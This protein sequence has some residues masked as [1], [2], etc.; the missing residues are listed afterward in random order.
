[1]ESNDT[2]SQAEA[3]P[4]RETRLN[5]RATA[6]QGALI[7]L[8]AQASSK[9]V[10]E[11]VLDSASNAAEQILADRRWFMLDSSSWAEFQDALER[12]VVTKPRLAE[13]LSE[14]SDL[15]ER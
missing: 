7:R 10:T 9:T 12:P 5:L 6:R 4:I 2:A 14:D 15:F 11:F 1:M 8:A 3:K 13:L